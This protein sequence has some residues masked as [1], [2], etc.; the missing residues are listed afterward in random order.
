M[1]DLKSIRTT[2]DNSPK[3]YVLDDKGLEAAIQ[4]AI[5][6]GKPLLLTGAPGTGKTQL[7]YK[8]AHML[9]SN[10]NTNGNTNSG[11]N[12]NV[13]PAPKHTPTKTPAKAKPKTSPVG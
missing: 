3:Y 2:E 5:W 12:S 1:F 10:G 9:S 11:S 13:R 7:A 4:M 8:V 6:L